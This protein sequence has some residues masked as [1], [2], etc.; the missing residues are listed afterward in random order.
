MRVYLFNACEKLVNFLQTSTKIL[1]Y[2][3]VYLIFGMH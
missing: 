1:S 2:N 3:S